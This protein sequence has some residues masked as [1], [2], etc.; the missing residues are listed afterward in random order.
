MAPYTAESTRPTQ[1]PNR[2]PPAIPRIVPAIPLTATRKQQLKRQAASDQ[3]SLTTAS[4]ADESDLSPLGLQDHAGDPM[5]PESLSSQAS[6]VANNVQTPATRLTE[7]A[8]G[9][10]ILEATTEGI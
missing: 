8:K 6:K 2:P 3:I 7:G 10:E 5:T 4:K 1:N 9:V